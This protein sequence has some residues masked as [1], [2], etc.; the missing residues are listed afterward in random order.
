MIKLINILS[1]AV[2]AVGLL[3][4]SCSKDDPQPTISVTDFTGSIAENPTMDQLIGVISATVENGN[5][6]H[7]TFTPQHTG[8]AEHVSISS[9]GELRV[10]N[11]DFFDYEQNT[12]I[13]GLAEIITFDDKENEMKASFSV[14]INITDVTEAPQT[15]YEVIKMATNH[16]DIYIWLYD[17]TPLHKTNFDSLTRAGFYNGLIFHRVI[18][19]FMIQGG[20]PTGTG[21]GGPGY[22]IPAEI[23]A[24]L[25]HDIGA[26]GAARKASTNKASNGSQFYI[27]EGPNGAHHL[28]GDY[29]V[30]G[31]TIG[32]MNV[33]SAIAAVPTNGSDKPLTDVVM[34]KVEVVKYTAAELLSEFNFTIPQ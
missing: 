20:D 26:V 27:V 22:L 31:Q 32:G 29:T 18:N 17:E 25:K 2:L 33:V 34:T 19:D 8:I 9:S 10:S 11:P 28:D 14:T 23:K 3:F 16:G 13:S 1:V 15:K 12:I 6:T 5:S 24:N 7:F 21:S 30:F 4:A